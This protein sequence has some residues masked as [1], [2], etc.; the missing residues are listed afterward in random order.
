MEID[1]SKVVEE[2]RNGLKLDY[3]QRILRQ[4]QGGLGAGLLSVLSQAGL[5]LEA[6][7]TILELSPPGIDEA[8]ALA[9]MMHLL[10]EE[11]G[12]SFERVVIDTAPTGHTLR[13]ISFPQ[14]LHG[15]VGVVLSLNEKVLGSS[16][17]A[18]ILG[19]VIG[20]DLQRQLEVSKANLGRVMAAM[21]TLNAVFADMDTT[22]FVVVSIPT[23]LAVAESIRLLRALEQAQMPVRHVVVNKCSFL[24]GDAQA[25]AAAAKLA[26]ADAR[27]LESL[28]GVKEAEMAALGRIMDRLSRQHRDAQKQVAALEQEAGPR[29]HMLQVPVFDE[30]LTGVAALDRYAE[31]LFTAA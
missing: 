26:R 25:Q 13:L 21:A 7:A 19:S 31:A 5:D 14:F 30:E 28:C 11:E 22:S 24:N 3:L 20:D 16:P 4:G 9:Q 27:C 29:V 10:G 1:P 2:F 18:R 17:F 8:V 12:S 15:V 23:H 6:L